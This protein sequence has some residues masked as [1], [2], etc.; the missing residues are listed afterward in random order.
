MPTGKLWGSRVPAWGLTLTAKGYHSLMAIVAAEL[1]SREVPFDFVDNLVVADRK[2]ARVEILL[3]P[4]VADCSGVTRGEW[5]A[6]VARHVEG[7]LA[8]P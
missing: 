7:A 4:L 3:P 2:G 8:E 1:K 5:A 6:I